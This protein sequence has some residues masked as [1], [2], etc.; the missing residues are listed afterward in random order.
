MEPHM[1]NRSTVNLT[2]N[3]LSVESTPGEPL[4]EAINRAGLKL[5]QICYH[6]QLGPIQTCDTCMVEVDGKLLRACGTRLHTAA[7][8]LTE[9]K[10]AQAARLEA[11]D[12]ILGNHELY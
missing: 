7:T 1:Q 4:I 2:I 10:R 5:P 6:P 8:I 12:V 9:S 11:M 3:G